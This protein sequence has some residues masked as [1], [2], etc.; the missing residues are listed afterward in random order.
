MN[1]VPL[2]QISPPQAARL[3]EQAEKPLQPMLAHPSR[4]LPSR[5]PESMSNAAP[6][7]TRTG[8]LSRF[9]CSCIQCSCLGVPRP[10]HSTSG[11]TCEIIAKIP[12]SSSLLKGRKAGN[13]FLRRVVQEN[14]ASRIRQAGLRRGVRPRRKS[15]DSLVLEF[16]RRT[17]AS[18]R[19][20]T[21]DEANRN[22]GADQASQ[23]ACHQSQPNLLR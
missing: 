14:G 19:A 15:A 5:L 2:D 20:R 17:P 7:P 9:L 4:R 13:G 8:T 22:H 3:L 18:N 12:L 11:A 23:A 16:V 10:T 6:T 21:R 1:W